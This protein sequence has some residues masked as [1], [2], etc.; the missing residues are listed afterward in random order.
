L[1]KDDPRFTPDLRIF[2]SQTYN[3]KRLANY[4]TGTGSEVSAERAA[5]A[6]EAAK[7]FVSHVAALLPPNGRTPRPPE[8][9]PKP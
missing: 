9:R 8:A 4:E 1:T 5:S 2:L 7:K 3:L 6:I